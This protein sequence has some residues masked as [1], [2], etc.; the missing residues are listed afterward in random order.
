[1]IGYAFLVLIA[2]GTIFMGSIVVGVAIWG[3]GQQKKAALAK[4]AIEATSAT[5][6]EISQ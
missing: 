3:W 6:S 4:A 2:L 5:S 1:M